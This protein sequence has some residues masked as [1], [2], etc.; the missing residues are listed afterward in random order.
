MYLF[1]KQSFRYFRNNQ[2]Q[3]IDAEFRSL[4]KDQDIGNLKVSGP[5]NMPV[6]FIKYEGKSIIILISNMIKSF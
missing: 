4:G 6:K 1:I 2:Q 5:D 3:G